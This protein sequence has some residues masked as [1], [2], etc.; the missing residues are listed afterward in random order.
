MALVVLV[1]G[2]GVD[3][4]GGSHKYNVS[5]GRMAIDV[6]EC[7]EA[8]GGLNRARFGSGMCTVLVSE[9]NDTAARTSLMIHVV[10]FETRNHLIYHEALVRDGRL[11]RPSCT[12]PERCA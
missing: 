6:A 9:P 8:P 3:V 10:I 1:E 4:G 11:V 7:A 2:S 12:D 5:I